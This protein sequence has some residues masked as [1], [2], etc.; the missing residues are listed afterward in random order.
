MI[1][2]QNFVA[3]TAMD[4]QDEPDELEDKKTELV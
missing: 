3:T 2:L 4:N 1:L